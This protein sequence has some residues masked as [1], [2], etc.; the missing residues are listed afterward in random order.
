MFCLTLAEKSYEGIVKKIKKASKYTDL[1]EIRADYLEDLEIPKL[2]SLIK[3]PYRFLF[4]F[5]SY[6][7][8]GYKRISDEF[9]LK[10]LLWAIRKDFYL[11]DIEWKLLRDFFFKLE[12]FDFNK[13]LVSYHNF[14]E[15]PSERY[16]IK[17]LSEMKKRGIKRAKIVCMCKT[18]EESFRLLNLIFKAKEMGIELISFGMGEKGRLSR[19]LSLF[20]GSPF[21]YVVFSKKEVV[22]PGQFDIKSAKKIYNIL[23]EIME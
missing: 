5:R 11:V 6:E 13:I 16:L 12:G 8:G 4:T 2:E 7:E 17:L 22:A 21:T 1:F 9:R 19:I 23:K 14:E 10:W 3:L 18:L 15:L 20:C